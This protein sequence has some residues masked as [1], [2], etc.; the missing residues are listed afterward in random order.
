MT[1]LLK[2]VAEGE[3]RTFGKFRILGLLGRG[4]M[5]AVYKAH[6]T[7]L[8]RVV[9]LKVLPEDDPAAVQ[10]FLAEAR[11]IAK[12]NHPHI[13]PIYEIGELEGV[14]FF[15]MKIIEGADLETLLTRD[16]PFDAR[17]AC[18]I[19]RD[20]ARAVQHA[21]AQGVIHRDLKPGNIL[22][23]R[24]GQPH[25]TDF[26]LAKQVG[27]DRPKM[28]RTG[29][30]VGTPLYM[31]PEQ[32]L[33]D[34][35]AVG[36]LSDVHAL[37]AVLY[38]LLTGRAP[39]DGES[40]FH[41]LVSVIEQEPK[42]PRE[43]RPSVHLDA[44]TICLKAMAKDPSRRYGS[45][46]AFAQDADRFVR[47]EPILA[48]P[49][50]TAE[51]A[52]RFVR[53]RRG[54][55]ISVA[56]A[57]VMAIA[58][59]ATWT[60]NAGRPARAELANLRPR[61]DAAYALRD[62][63]AAEPL[64]RRMVAIDPSDREAAR[65]HADCTDRIARAMDMIT[66]V[67]ATQGEAQ[68]DRWSDIIDLLPRRASAWAQRGMATLQHQGGRTSEML[69][70]LNRALELDPDEPTAHFV[71]G[72]YYEHYR[73]DWA[74]ARAHYE[75][76]LR[77]GRDRHS[78]LQ[79][80]AM[81]VRRDGQVEKALEMLDEAAR[82]G[83]DPY[84]ENSRGICLM[85]LGR[86]SDAITAFDQSIKLNPRIAMAWL[87]RA[88]LFRKVRDMPQALSDARRAV[89]LEPTSCEARCV[90]GLMLEDSGKL[91]EA[92]AALDEAVR[93]LPESESR[94]A[95]G[96][97]LA[98][99]GRVAEAEAEF[100]EVIQKDPACAEAFHQ[101]G[102]VRAGQGRNEAAEEDLRRALALEPQDKYAL[103]TLAMVLIARKRP[104]EALECIDRI[105]AFDKDDPQIVMNRGSLLRDLGRYDEA[106]AA[107]RSV[108]TK[109]PGEAH[110][111]IGFIHHL[112]RQSGEAETELTRSIEAGYVHAYYTRGAARIWAGDARGAVDDF[113]KAAVV[114][115]SEKRRSDAAYHAAGI[116]HKYKLG[117]K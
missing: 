98:R 107:Y 66:A 109:C 8:D 14:H 25:V 112:L 37:G 23:D 16:G 3:T 35:A 101:R 68:V 20:A 58:G 72:R 103:N 18:E 49:P 11:A 33:G 34:A 64:Y 97:F 110:H 19:A 28:T 27:G 74:K 102:D 52:W 88:R 81:L 36:P 79:A 45:A 56:A 21:H 95:R 93:L 92:E 69:R 47:G 31:S 62:Y 59:I 13:V 117:D 83:K 77:S 54:A 91:A 17:R 99:R 87:N 48:R 22:L 26:G 100:T 60:W 39:F 24:A 10:R 86:T 94:L 1:D 38:A 71:L 15:T 106:L 67:T 32:A 89:E 12:L 43:L 115:R 40:S 70:D 105:L 29:D 57:L 6:Q 80:A 116:R 30:I 75:A 9:A 90:L 108:V 76:A 63:D 82:L 41:I 84:V 5:G 104:V 96:R 42:P 65:H 61:A 7:D 55:A 50:T 46:N 44:Q 111:E 4:G 78:S 85:Q 2:G 73:K 113:E 114:D 53:R 51:R